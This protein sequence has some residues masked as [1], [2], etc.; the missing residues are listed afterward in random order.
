MAHGERPP[1]DDQ[2][3]WPALDSFHE[4]DR[5]FFRGRAEVTNELLR[6][7]LRERV[8]VLY[9]VS[10]IGKSSLLEAGLFP[11]LRQQGA[12]PVDVRF[13]FSS[14]DPDLTGQ[15]KRAIEAQA[16]KGGV[17]APKH[18]EFETLWE[19]FH[20]REQSFWDERNRLVMPVLVFDQFEELFTLG[21]ERPEK[22][23]RAR[24]LLSQLADLAEGRAPHDLAEWLE[25]HPESA[26]NYNFDSHQYRILIGIREDY[27][28]HLEDLRDVMPGIVLNR[29]RLWAMDGAS[30][31]EVVNQARHLIAPE[32]AEQVVRFVARAGAAANLADMVVEPALLSV[33]CS[34]LNEKRKA[35]GEQLISADLL[36]GSKDEILRDFYRR[37]TG[38]VSE[39]TRRF[40]E[41]ELI[42][43]PGYRDTVAIEAALR[44]PG[45]TE[46]DVARLVKRRLVR[47]EERG[48]VRRVELTHDLLIG[49]IR[50]SRDKRHLT[51]KT[52]QEK[53]AREAAEQRELAARR[54]LRRTR[55]LATVFVSLAIAAGVMAVWALIATRDALRA[56]HET[57]VTLARSQVQQGETSHEQG[58]EDNFALAYFARALRI[59]PT[60]PAARPWIASLFL[61]GRLSRMVFPHEAAVNAAAFSPDGKWIVTAC[62]DNAAHL[63]EA[64]TGQAV[65]SPMRHAGAVLAAAFSP[66]GQW[67]VTGSK[68]GTAQ[69]WEAGTGKAHGAPMR[70]DNEVHQAIFSANSDRV[71]TAALDNTARV[72]QASTGEAIARFLDLGPSPA[73]LS[74]DGK[75]VATAVDDNAVQVWDVETGKPVGRA[76]THGGSVQAVVFSPDG[77]RVATASTD[78]TGRIWDAATGRP[79]TPPLRHKDSVYS[80][81][82]SPDGTQVV[83]ASADHTSQ[84]WNAQT[85][86]PVGPPMRQGDMV[87]TAVFSPDGK[88]I[89][90]RSKPYYDMVKTWEAGTGIELGLSIQEE[91]SIKSAEF[92]PDGRWILTASVDKTARVWPAFAN[93][94][95]GLELPHNDEVSRPIFSPD[96]RWVV[97]APGDKTARIWEAAT[98]K[99]V[100]KPMPLSGPLQAAAFSPDG[101]RIVTADSTGIA[102]VWDAVSGDP[103]GRALRHSATVNSAVFS[104]DGRWVVT[105]SNDNTA[106]V[107]DAKTG[108]PVGRAMHHDDSVRSAVF[109]PDGDL[110][111]TASD[112]KT[113]RLW[114]ARTGE[115]AAPPMRHGGVVYSATFSPDGSRVL[116]AS[117]DNTARLWR[118]RTAQ[119]LAVMLHDNTVT[120]AVFSP[121]GESLVTVSQNNAQMWN[122]NGKKMGVAMTRNVA[123]GSAVFSPDNNWV[124][125]GLYD[126]T[127][128]LWEAATGKPVGLPLPHDF[129][130]LSAAFSPDARWILT[131]SEGARVW[132]SPASIKGADALA[133]LAEV[134][135][136]YQITSLGTIDSASDIPG[137]YRKLQQIAS[138]AQ[139]GDFTAPSL[140]KWY[141][142]SPAERTI[143]PGLT[144]PVCGYIQQLIAAGKGEEMATAFPAHA[145]FC[146]TK[147]DGAQ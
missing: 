134:V 146:N 33:M 103:I 11:L 71:L 18:A 46:A 24:E 108:N 47:I 139:F 114:K 35:R 44:R 2:N 41:E 28:A 137:R 43:D 105:A 21:A 142:S 125:T 87:A 100:G 91:D 25:E 62:D 124:L 121:S 66:D 65:G 57:V 85:G 145:L 69:V 3:P 90:T 144:L 48:G 14:D 133:D 147:S 86:Q 22:Q 140:I 83:T 113:A 9:G 1:L 143:S 99:R 131:M 98:G 94:A 118:T 60:Y 88:Q 115:G 70:H 93:R 96:S 73:A 40:I 52:D 19:Y 53:A 129:F 126:K 61:Q 58:D 117:A 49:V 30:A 122:A 107:W 92:S 111:L 119:Q 109:S 4:A 29:K 26:T 55:A 77:K 135:G 138:T 82:F 54:S 101:K 45:V 59:D 141:F 81:A 76:L 127:A 89:L 97:T 5:K 56:Q 110:V 17:E 120:S 10:G 80:I 75:W 34:E 50:E 78:D 13:D 112:D 72:W 136:G 68:D 128:Q 31:L 74:P 130:V 20:R 37:A 64:A 84:I 106:Q 104:P 51:E 38:D 27:L 6:L 23:A 63:W 79:A 7:V 95:V 8:T 15:V 16:A 132:P 36:Q 42:L 12:L 102:Q 39:G 32:V 67:I 116:T 123:I